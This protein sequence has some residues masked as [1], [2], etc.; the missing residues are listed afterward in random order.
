MHTSAIDP[1][2]PQSATPVP[3]LVT[4]AERIAR[5]LDQR[6]NPQLRGLPDLLLRALKLQEEAG[7]LAGAVTG[8]LGHNPRKGHTHTWDDVL[9]E[10]VDVALTALAFAESVRPGHLRE[11][12]P[13]R[14][15]DLE[16]RA[17]ASGAPTIPPP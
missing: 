13:Q 12:L 11:H 1:T 14:L 16:Q 10:A 15:T 4:A 17:A 3:T 6:G 7:E 9:A 5:Q 8:V 2:P